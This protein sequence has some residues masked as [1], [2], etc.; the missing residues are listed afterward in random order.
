[1]TARPRTTNGPVLWDEL[2][3]PE[4]RALVETMKMAIVP[5]GAVEQHGPHLPLLV[6]YVIVHEVAK[7]ASALTGVPVLPP[8]QYGFSGSHGSFPGTIS[9]QLETML[10]ILMDICDWLYR[11]GV[12]KI[13]LLN[14]QGMN[15]GP[16]I[17]ATEKIATTLGEDLRIKGLFYWDTSSRARSLMMQ[18]G[19][20]DMLNLHA[21][22]AE[23]AVMLAIRPDLVKMNRVVDEPDVTQAVWHY[24][25]DQMTRSGIMG[26]GAGEAS[27]ALGEEILQGWTEELVIWIEKALEEDRPVR[28]DGEFFWDSDGVGDRVGN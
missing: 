26:T 21:N 9:L 22:K 6:D 11:S 20:H 8:L 19:P 25:K 1:M 13:L 5:L 3:H 10:Q 18:K 2:T 15:R 16:L 17:T 23:T 28:T 27:A 24:R 14:G 7:R 12:R 4:I